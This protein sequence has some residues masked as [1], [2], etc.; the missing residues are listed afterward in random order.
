MIAV[1]EKNYSAPALTLPS[2]LL[3]QY[4]TK[5]QVFSSHRPQAFKILKY[6]V[7]IGV[8]RS[9]NG[10]INLYSLNHG[11]SDTYNWNQEI[12][13][14]TSGSD[15]IGRRVAILLAA[16]GVKVAVLDIQPLKY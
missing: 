9:L 5:V 11:T 1:L 12:A 10:L 14:V 16:R 15:G 13:I 8:I 3:S 7:A 4:I 6:L 2:Y